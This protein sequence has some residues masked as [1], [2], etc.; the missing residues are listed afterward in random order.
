MKIAYMM[1]RF[2]HLP[3][4]FIL[5]EMIW[6]EKTGWQIALYPLICQ[7]QAVVHAEAQSWLS[8]ARCFPYFSAQVL[9]SNLKTFFSQPLVYL[10]TWARMVAGNLSSPKFLLRALALYP[11][12]VA[13]A[14]AMR[15]EKIDHIHAHYA[16]H[17]ALAAWVIHRLTGISYSLTVHAHDI[18]VERPMLP[19]KLCSALFIIAISQFNRDFLAR[20]VGE[21]VRAKTHVVH[22][23]IDPQLYA[24]RSPR[25]PGETPF[26]ILCIGSLQ[27]YKGLEYLV[28]ACSRL[29]FD[30]VC[31]VIGEGEQRGAL[32]AQI[33]RLGLQSK[34]QL[35]GAKTQ[36]EV[37]SLLSQADCYVQPSVIQPNGKMEGIPVAL[38]EALAHGLPV[39]ATQIS[40]IPELVQ[41]GVT[42]LLVP[43]RSAADLANAITRVFEHPADVA[44]LAAAGR[45][46]VL[47]EFNLNTTCAT[48]A[49]LFSQYLPD[50]PSG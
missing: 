8:R 15:Q 12:M 41:P 46:L 38:M 27:P 50:T 18:Y 24:G 49:S 43:Q 3:E 7:E 48:I 36:Q 33:Q 47:Q 34:V 20:E 11:K 26:R 30:Y 4:T 23:G 10:S 9:R 45:Q 35:L 31:Q 44:P 13:M 2:P 19:A 25:P 40:G 1:S 22:C 37:A 6:V 21:W 32:D 39:I 17:P 42:G 5:R 28:D 16:T 14:Q 29:T